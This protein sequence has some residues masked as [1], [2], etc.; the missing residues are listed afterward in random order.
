MSLLTQRIMESVT[1]TDGGCWE[2]NL[3]R[4]RLGY[5]RVRWLDTKVYHAHRLAYMEWIGPIPDDL[6]VDHLC[7]NRACVNPAHLELVTHAENLTRSP[8][9]PSAVNARKTHCV[10]GHPFDEENTYLRPG[11]NGQ[12]WR[13]CR[14]CAKNNA[15]RRAS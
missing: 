1:I 9:Q 3:T 11:R 5:G 13:Q 12:T 2:W 8:M 7:R 6:E 14:A 4:T 10:N 15:K